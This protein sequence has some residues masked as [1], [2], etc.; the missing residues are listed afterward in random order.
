MH[1]LTAGHSWVNNQWTACHD[2]LY[3]MT[4]LA[5]HMFQCF[6]V[7][8]YNIRLREICI[9]QLQL[10]LQKVTVKVTS[11]VTVTSRV[12]VTA[13]VTASVTEKVTET[14][15]YTYNDNVTERS[16]RAHWIPQCGPGNK[17]ADGALYASHTV[18]ES[19]STS[20]VILLTQQ[21]RLRVKK[22]PPMKH[23]YS[24]NFNL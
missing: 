23:V 10:D 20:L 3:H 22:I 21:P 1:N 7:F 17:A 24:F 13:R 6:S 12:T 18:S 8:L 14:E 19:T 16:F 4:L 11:W 9:K 5:S 15:S 2:S